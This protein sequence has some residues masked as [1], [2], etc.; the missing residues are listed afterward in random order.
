MLKIN[1]LFL[2]LFHKRYCTTFKLQVHNFIRCVSPFVGRSVSQ[3]VGRDFPQEQ[4]SDHHYHPNHSNHPT[5]PRNRLDGLTSII[6][7]QQQQAICHSYSDP[8]KE[9]QKKKLRYS[10]SRGWK[11]EVANSVKHYVFS[12]FVNN[13]HWFILGW[14]RNAL[15]FYVHLFSLH[16][17]N[18]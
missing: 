3:L 17:Y 6:F 10:L 9:K 16:W 7:V 1:F 2:K 11:W 18:L 14:I 5:T 13:D 8:L 12:Y 4:N 15:Y